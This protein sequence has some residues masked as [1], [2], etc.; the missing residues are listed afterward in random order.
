MPHQVATDKKEQCLAFSQ[1]DHRRCR[2]RRLYGEKTC[3]VHRKYYSDWFVNHQPWYRL[4]WLS[5]REKAEFTFQI[6]QGHIYI[7]EHHVRQLQPNLEEYYR[8]LV[9][10]AKIPV[11]WNMNCLT[12]SLLMTMKRMFQEVEG[13]EN[14]ITFYLNTANDCSL[15]L[16]ELID[17]WV[18]ILVQIRQ[19]S[20]AWMSYPTAYRYLSLL[21]QKNEQWRQIAFSGELE[22]WLVKKASIPHVAGSFLA[23][24]DALY[25]RP[26][27]EDFP[28]MFKEWCKK[29]IRQ[30]M[31]H[32]KEELMQVTWHPDKVSAMLEAGEEPWDI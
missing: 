17:A 27:Q 10:Y 13:A 2:L 11:Q 22:K 7:P 14:E 8:F 15:V 4:A 9:K 19:D 3:Y 30:Q 31:N 6:S 20:L 28:K 25:L 26:L 23:M 24:V 5:E 12:N 18:R 21:V 1:K 32:F 29:G 16:Q